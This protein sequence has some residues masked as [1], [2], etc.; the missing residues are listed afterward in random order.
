VAPRA[1]G[2][3]HRRLRR[4]IGHALAAAAQGEAAGRAATW[5][6]EQLQLGAAA[7]GTPAAGEVGAIAY[8]PGARSAALSGGIDSLLRDQWRRAGTQA[9]LTLDA[10]PLG[11]PEDEP[12][13]APATTTTTT[14]TTTV[15]PTT[16]TAPPPSTTVGPTSTATTATVP[17]VA[18][19]TAAADDD[20][21]ELAVTGSSTAAMVV[22]G[23]LLLLA[24]AAALAGGRVGRR[25]GL[26]I[27]AVL[28]GFGASALGAPREAGAT[29]VA[30]RAAVVGSEGA[31]PSTDGVTVVVDFAGLGGGVHV[32]CAPGSPASGFDALDRAGIAYDTALR[33]GGFLCRI[34]GKPA[35]DPCIDPSPASA[36]WSYWLAE[37][38]GSWCYSSLG[39]GNRR[40]PQG[41]V[42]GW[43]FVQ[44]SGAADA[45]PPAADPPAAVTG[46]G[47][48]AAADCDRS[49]TAPTTPPVIAA[50]VT[51]AAAAPPAGQPTAGSGPPPAD[52]V[53]GLPPDG[54]TGA[55]DPA[56]GAGGSTTG[57]PGDPAVTTSIVPSDT[58]AP[59]ATDVSTPAGSA[60][61]PGAGDAETAAA[62]RS[63]QEASTVDLSDGGRNG[64]AGPFGTVAAAGGAAALLAGAV[65][66][67]R[68]RDRPQDDTTAPDAES[69]GSVTAGSPDVPEPLGA[70]ATVPGS[71]SADADPDPDPAQPSP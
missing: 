2:R 4:L 7:A 16:T 64:G 32:R 30:L 50:P 43:S 53:A 55:D 48:L 44:G 31:C 17:A 63:A 40:P 47:T 65:V 24:G 70:L 3:D 35:T 15:V 56:P 36:H 46:A 71:C 1:G 8:D 19:A 54:G 68:R 21:E 12:P 26:G 33:S 34:A 25:A 42:E 38:G 61:F 69:E 20:A 22:A 18:G 23:S 9:V 29:A 14:T 49:A 37:R 59:P 6:I 45:R 62:R 66:L 10:P 51:P 13:V 39:A 11:V 28:G 27:V 60:T 57:A 67:R 58:A 41:T 52:P 5:V